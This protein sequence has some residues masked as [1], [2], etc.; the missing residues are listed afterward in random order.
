MSVGESGTGKEL[1]A[2][3]IHTLDPRTNK[4]DL[5]VSDCTTI[6]ISS[7]SL[8]GPYVSNS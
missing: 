4:R 7:A 8:N 6:S 5:V 1:I 2:R 3:L